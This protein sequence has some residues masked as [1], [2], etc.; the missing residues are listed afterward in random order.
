MAASEAEPRSSLGK[1][2]T[3]GIEGGVDT[4]HR[5]VNGKRNPGGRRKKGIDRAGAK[6]REGDAGGSVMKGGCQRPA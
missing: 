4:R 1:Q 5:S 6:G 2:K 3:K